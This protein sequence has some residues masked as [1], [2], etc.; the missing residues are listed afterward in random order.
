MKGTMMPFPLTLAPLLERAG[1]LFP[2]VEIVSSRPDD[3]IHRYSYREMH[4]RARSLAAAL[5]ALGLQRGDA[6]LFAENSQSVASRLPD[7]Q[8]CRNAY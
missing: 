7:S 1:K 8:R 2:T 4:Q 3:S 6:R 5:Q